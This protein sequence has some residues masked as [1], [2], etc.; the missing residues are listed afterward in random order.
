MTPTRLLTALL[1]AM[2]L[3]LFAPASSF[4]RPDTPRERMEA[5]KAQAKARHKEAKN[6]SKKMMDDA[7]SRAN[8]LFAE[9]LRKSWQERDSEAPVVRPDDKPVVVPPPPPQVEPVE[10]RPVV[11]EEV[12]K[13]PSLLPDLDPIFEI[14]LDDISL[15]PL[16]TNPDVAPKPDVKPVEKPVSPASTVTVDFFGT[17]LTLPKITSISAPAGTSEEAIASAWTK[18]SASIPAS[19]PAALQNARRELDLCDWACL[20]LA[21]KYA[22]T[23]GNIS[24]NR[25]ALLFTWLMSQAGYDVRL[26]RSGSRLVPLFASEYLIYQH[27]YFSIGG[28]R[29]YPL[30]RQTGSM[31][32]CQ[33]SFTGSRPLS[34]TVG[35]RMNLTPSPSAPRS[36]EARGIEAKVV[37]DRNLIDF[38]AQFP[39]SQYSDSEESR[40]AILAATPLSESARNSLYPVLN[41]AIKGKNKAEAV[42]IILRYLQHGLLYKYDEEIWGQDRA[43]FPEETL[44]YPYAD[45][46]DR[47]ALF[48]RLVKDLTGLP[49]ALVVYPGH[50]AAA[51]AFPTHE[52]GDYLTI[53]GR[54]FLICDPTYIGVGIGVSMPD[55]RNQP[56]K[57]VEV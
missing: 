22:E 48:V 44:Y 49:A 13:L 24:D 30:D 25:V 4:A 56:V 50:V 54:R 21:R 46:E 17:N 29:Y 40:W 31:A 45:C 26:G 32:I 41:D 28:K 33:Q 16:V 20:L 7:R 27:P 34:M 53:S 5:V 35:K 6:R 23:T 57:V 37:T 1:P 18:M 55:L 15:P 51:V 52:E 36:L 9:T 10:T 42:N 11:I 12:V 19:V 38:Y 2:V 3:I 43:F 8:A 14:S 39:A 47:A